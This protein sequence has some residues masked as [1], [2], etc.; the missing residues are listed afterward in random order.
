[1]NT[2]ISQKRDIEEEK[3]CKGEMPLLEKQIE[4]IIDQASSIDDKPLN[5]GTSLFILTH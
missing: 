1:M 4:F 2:E 3:G 5:P